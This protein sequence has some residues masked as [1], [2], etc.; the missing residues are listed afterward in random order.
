LRPDLRLLDLRG[1]VD[2]RLRKLRE[3]NFEAIVL[4][5]AGLRRLGLRGPEES[6][7]PPELFL[8]A[9]GQGA[10]GL[11]YVEAR[12]DLASLLAFM[13]H[14]P[15][16]LRVEAERSFL[17]ALGGNCQTPI[18]AHASLAEEGKLLLDGLVASPDG[19]CVIRR[20]IWGDPAEAA[21]LGRELAEQILAAGGRETLI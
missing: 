10:L 11:E 12:R 2:T 8:P 4:A 14:R 15:T 13:E 5:L 17:R 16:R 9:C 6:V 20:R 19:S 21:R 1:N 18:A 7:L 3:G